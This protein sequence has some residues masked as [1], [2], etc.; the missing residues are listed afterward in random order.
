MANEVVIREM[1]KRLNLYNIARLESYDTDLSATDYIESLLKYEIDERKKRSL[2]N[3]R[4]ISH[5][6]KT[7]ETKEF[8]GI[9]KWMTAKLKKCDWIREEGNLVIF[10]KCGTGKTA[11]ATTLGETALE[12]GFKVRYIT[13]DGIIECLYKKDTYS[14][15]RKVY[16]SLLASDLIILDEMMYLPISEE[17]LRVLYK[18]LIFLNE[19]RSVIIITNRLLTD[20]DKASKDK[21]TMETLKDRLV[22]NARLIYLK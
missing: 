14:K 19:S 20:W 11:L 10:G 21:H 7:R 16:E 4:N 22:N 18:G 15:E 1:A 6:P 8:N 5:L 17:D 3:N 13:M 9:T 12:Q 2:E